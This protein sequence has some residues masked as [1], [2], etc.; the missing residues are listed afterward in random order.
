MYVRKIYFNPV[1]TTYQYQTRCGA[2]RISG[3][4]VDTFFNIFLRPD[5]TDRQEAGCLETLE[6]SES[7]RNKHS[8]TNFPKS[9]SDVDSRLACISRLLFL[10]PKHQAAYTDFVD[11]RCCNL[12]CIMLINIHQWAFVGTGAKWWYCIVYLVLT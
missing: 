9:D 8:K 12:P 10:R 3:S 1:L 11:N 6:S 2:P 5:K 7:S 4:V